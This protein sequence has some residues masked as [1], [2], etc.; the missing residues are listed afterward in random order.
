FSFLIYATTRITFFANASPFPPRDK[1]SRKYN[2]ATSAKMRSLFDRT[3]GIIKPQIQY[4]N[5]RKNA[6]AIL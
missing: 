3:C 2:G 5:I 6:I 4:C 1:S